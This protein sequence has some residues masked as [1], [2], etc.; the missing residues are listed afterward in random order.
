MKLLEIWKS[1]GTGIGLP[2]IFPLR[3]NPRGDKALLDQ[4]VN[5]GTRTVKGIAAVN[6]LA[7]RK[8]RVGR[9]VKDQI[10]GFEAAAEEMEAAM[11]AVRELDIE[12]HNEMES[13]KLPDTLSAFKKRVGP[14]KGEESETT[15]EE[16]ESEEEEPK[17]KDDEV[18][19]DV[20][21]EDVGFEEERKKKKKKLNLKSLLSPCGRTS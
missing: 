4:L 17:E 3:D 6:G 13:G 1:Q 20:T 14:K 16:E 9:D 2:V 10:R 12:P 18:D 11:K 7:L 15:L 21:D 19:F 8:M 5:T